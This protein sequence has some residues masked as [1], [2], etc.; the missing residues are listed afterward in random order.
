MK[1]TF[2]GAAGTVTGAKYLVETGD[3]KILVDCGLFQ[4]LKQLRLINWHELPFDPRT[5]DAV[6]ITHAHVD[7]SGYLPV[8]FKRGY[9]GPIYCTY[10]S[11]ELCR[12]LLPDAAYLQ[13]EEARYA[14]KK[15][16]SKHKP[17]LP[18]FTTEE[19]EGCL[20]L[21]EG[22]NFDESVSL[23]KN[24]KFRFT[25]AGHI[26]GAACVH[27]DT[28]KSKL[29]FSGDVGRLHDVVMNPPQAIEEAD[30]LVVESTY[31]NRRH[32]HDDAKDELEKVVARTLSR[33]GVVLIPSF[34][35]GRAQ[36]LL[37]LLSRLKAE[38]KIGD[39]PI[40]LNSP[41]ANKATEI[42]CQFHD[43]H[44]LSAEECREMCRSI[45][46]VHSVDES[47]ALNTKKGPMIIISASGM[48]TGGRILHHLKVFA[49]DP[50]NTILFVGFQAAGTR[51]EAMIHGVEEI[52][53][54]GQY[55]PIKAE[56]YH[57]DNL[58]AHADYAEMLTWLRQMK[59]PPKKTFIVHGEPTA[60]DAFRRNLRDQ[61][62]WEAII[63]KYRETFQLD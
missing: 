50:K 18:L 49:P 21:F 17:A 37:Y 9:R 62:G 52:K 51:G 23:A 7:H 22:C 24:L 1:I 55:T 60:Q 44:H 20:Q 36:A 12:L 54:H 43:E 42:F 32:G 25:P 29:V 27:L 38:K 5:L 58:S 34:A 4:G 33:N 15:K 46:S 57:M 8:L 10:G 35:V 41:M 6:V 11:L 47:K 63:P 26:I 28:G 53:I 31:G 56:V 19:A 2:F 40:Y 48:A 16:F 45:H 61:L 39:V 3:K 59:R 30:F 14:N 13:E